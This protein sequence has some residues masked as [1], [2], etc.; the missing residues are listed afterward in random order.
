MFTRHGR[1]P[2]LAAEQWPYPAHSVFNPGF[3]RLGPAMLPD[4]KDAALLAWLDEHGEAP[5]AGPQ[6]GF[7][8]RALATR[9][10]REGYGQAQPA[11]ILS[12]PIP[13]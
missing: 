9:S 6:R 1:R 5:G 13:G 8:G 7:R 12:I 4:N 10:W 2:I 11:F 3:R